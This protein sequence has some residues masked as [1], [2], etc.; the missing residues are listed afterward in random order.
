MIDVQDLH[1]RS[2]EELR[3]MAAHIAGILAHRD[4]DGGAQTASAYQRI[5]DRLTGKPRRAA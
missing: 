4:G 1:D 5:A 3:E 2:S